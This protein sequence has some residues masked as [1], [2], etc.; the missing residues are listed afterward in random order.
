MNLAHE[1]KNTYMFDQYEKFELEN[2]LDKI[3]FFS[4]VELGMTMYDFIIEHHALSSIFVPI[5]SFDDKKKENQNSEFVA[6]MEGVV[7]PW[8]GV[9]YRADRI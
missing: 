2:I 8:F 7:Y 6:A 1:P 5:C 4:D 9:G 3:K